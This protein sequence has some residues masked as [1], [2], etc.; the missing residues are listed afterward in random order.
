MPK[1]IRV[2]QF[3][4]P[5]VL[6]LG[7]VELPEPQPGEVRVTVRIAGV[8]PF[9][10][11][12]RQGTYGSTAFPYTPGIDLAG[13][14]DA[15][16]DGA[17]FAVGDEVFGTAVGGSYAEYALSTNLARKPA[18]VSWELAA[19]LPTP[20]EA[21]SR[22]L[23]LLSL[24][25]GETVLIHGAA[26]AVGSLATQLAVRR[27]ITVIGS[28]AESDFDFT[29]SI[30]AT[31]VRYGDGLADRV[32]EITP[33]RVDAVLDTTGAGVLPVSVELAGGS[34]RVVTL[35]D[36]NADKYGVRFSS[37]GADRDVNALS[38]VADLAGGG[39]LQLAIWRSYPLAE[40]ATAHEDIEQRRN[41]GKIL[42]TP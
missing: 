5:E 24:Q 2:A 28:V 19:A 12:F 38:T 1:A 11:K 31:P 33:E 26:G 7:D 6:Q 35:A 39:E 13:V 41:R 10:V 40:A 18:S 36:G 25:A 17:D 23:G 4:G 8:N 9:D 37:G 20:G 34:E 3:G 22:S 15:A 29:R 16:G 30:G 27:G 21:A 42:L 14:V 32:R